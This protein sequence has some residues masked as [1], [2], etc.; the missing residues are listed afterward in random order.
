MPR[1]QKDAQAALKKLG[2]RLRQGW[3]KQH[4]VPEKSLEIVKD[5]VREQ[6]EQDHKAKRTK[7]M[8]N[9]PTKGREPEGPD[10]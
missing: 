10:R 4:P 6:W 8:G 3:A 2:Q 5:T 9:T 1:E 7:K